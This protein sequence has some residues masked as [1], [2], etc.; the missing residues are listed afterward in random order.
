MLRER[1][2]ASRI[3]VSRWVAKAGDR[4]GGRAADRALL[5]RARVPVAWS[6]PFPHHPP[7]NTSRAFPQK[8]NA[9]AASTDGPSL[10]AA[11]GGCKRRHPRGQGATH[12]VV[13]LV[14][15][16]G[17]FAG[18]H[19]RDTGLEA[20]AVLFQAARLFAVASFAVLPRVDVVAGLERNL[21]S[22][23]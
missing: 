20:L 23:R 2:G 5:Q 13:R 16:L 10:R 14:L 15:T 7:L 6:L 19:A 8:E 11:S 18:G 17:A 12:V 1:V 9:L 3:G 22:E 4:E 21:G